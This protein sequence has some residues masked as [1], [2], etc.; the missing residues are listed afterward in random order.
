MLLR[1]AFLYNIHLSFKQPCN[2][3]NINF[4]I[5]AFEYVEK[6]NNLPKVM[7]ESERDLVNQICPIAGRVR[8]TL[9]NELEC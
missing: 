5:G 9:R 8:K 1:R 7:L 4:Y 6:L 2:M 3:E